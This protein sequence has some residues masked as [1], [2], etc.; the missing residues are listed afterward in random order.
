MAAVADDI[1]SIVRGSV[2]ATCNQHYLLLVHTIDT[3]GTDLVCNMVQS[4]VQIVNGFRLGN[5]TRAR[6]ILL[7]SEVRRPWW[8]SCNR[9]KLETTRDQSF[10]SRVQSG[11]MAG[12]ET[13]DL[14]TLY[15]V[16]I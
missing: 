1:E 14:K 8:L 6:R 4:F 5:T 11:S 12:L 15:T 16:N 13:A 7:G 2:P 10:P 3:Q 9:K